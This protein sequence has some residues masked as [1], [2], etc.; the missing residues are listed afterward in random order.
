MIQS[1]SSMSAVSGNQSSLNTFKV[2]MKAGLTEA[3]YTEQINWFATGKD[4]KEKTAITTLN[5]TVSAVVG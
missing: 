3:S 5:G 2:R 4:T 1:K